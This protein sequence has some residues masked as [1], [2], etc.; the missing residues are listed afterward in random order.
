MNTSEKTNN[1]ASFPESS[2]A[3]LPDTCV[4]KNKRL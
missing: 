1:P 2:I 4:K 3:D